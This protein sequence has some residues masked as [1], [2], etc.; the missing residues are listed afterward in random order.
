MM[1]FI[2]DRATGWIAWAIVI[3]ISIPFALWGIQEYFYADSAV[4]VARVNGTELTLQQY[5]RAQQQ[6]LAQL[7]GVLGA[8]F[9]LSRLDQEQIRRRTLDVLVNEEVVQQGGAD[10]GMRVGDVQLARAIQSV[11][12]FQIENEFSSALY[13][14]YLRNEG[15]STGGFEYQLRRSIVSEQLLA[16]LAQSAIATDQDLGNLVRLTNQART[17]ETLRFPVSD[18]SDIEVDEASVEAYYAQHQDEL[19]TPERIDVEYIE[20]SRSAIA[21]QL[22]VDEQELRAF[23]DAQKVNYVQP[24]SRRASHILVRVPSDADDAAVEQARQSLVEA[25]Q[26][27]DAGESFETLAK[28]ISDDPGSAEQAGDLGFFERGLMDPA[29]ED[30]AFELE[31]GQVSNPVR[32][33]FGFHLI[34]LT[35]VRSS[36]EQDFDTIRDRIE[37]EYRGEQAERVFFEQIERLAR[38]TFEHPDTLEI[39]ADELGLTIET[40]GF[41]ARNEPSEDPTSAEPAVVDAAFS[42]DVREAGNNSELVELPGG[43]AIVLRVKESQPSRPLELSEARPDIIERLREEAS[44]EAAQ[45]AGE[46][47]LEQLRGGGEEQTGREWEGF[48]AVQRDDVGVQ[49]DVLS[50]VFRMPR[51]AAGVPELSGITTL[52]GDYIVIRLTE[53]E[54]GGLDSVDGEQL[55]AA[56]QA[57]RSAYGQ[58]EYGAFVR[59]LRD[60]SEIDVNEESLR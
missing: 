29:F 1:Q 51:P 4:A 25:K 32:S 5:Q 7:R 10:S 60:Q 49:R 11:K 43:R 13:D 47:V 59:G 46:A 14:T 23:Y 57:L 44:R 39:A 16:G 37:Q 27:L 28:E 36:G 30:A 58:Q 33:S 8:A 17:F 38:L 54:D 48:D 19:Q 26:R 6:Q 52:A 41:F 24:E 20:L 21:E 18:Y 45:G 12:L 55:T 42:S 22:V 35:E 56:T 3:L 15:Y 50:E 2:R 40:T 53:V 34:K 31:P 9:D